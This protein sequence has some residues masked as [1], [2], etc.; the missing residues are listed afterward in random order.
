MAGE[1]AAL[2]HLYVART[3]GIVRQAAQLSAL[4]RQRV[5]LRAVGDRDP[6][7]LAGLLALARFGGRELTLAA[8]IL[9]G[10]RLREAALMALPDWELNIAHTA[11]TRDRS[12]VGRGLVVH[13]LRLDA[14]G[15]AQDAARAQEQAARQVAG[16]VDPARAAPE[17]ATDRIPV[18]RWPG[19]RPP[20]GRHAGH[21]PEEPRR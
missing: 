8:T 11:L 9:P 17:P 3:P 2:L 4:R 6:E 14:E 15:S 18:L 13:D 12:V 10:S 20:G 7:R 21:T 1:L 5:D 19:L 16:A